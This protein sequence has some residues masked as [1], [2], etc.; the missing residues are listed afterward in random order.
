MREFYGGEEVIINKRPLELGTRLKYYHH[1]RMQELEAVVKS[2]GV[3]FLWVVDVNEPP[4]GGSKDHYIVYDD[5]TAI[6]GEP[7][8]QDTR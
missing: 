8:V 2:A 6:M 5:I 1:E 4:P 7:G 3:F